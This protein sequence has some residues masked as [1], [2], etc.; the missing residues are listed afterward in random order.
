[1][2]PHVVLVMFAY[3]VY[4]VFSYHSLKFLHIQAFSREELQHVSRMYMCMFCTRACAY[5]IPKPYTDVLKW[6]LTESDST[7][8]QAQGCRGSG[9]KIETMD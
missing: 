2:Y 4:S 1:M 7:P 5:Q 3:D 8:R 9:C 6:A